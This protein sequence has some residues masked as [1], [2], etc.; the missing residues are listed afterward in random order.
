MGLKFLNFL[1]MSY[2]PQIFQKR[3]PGVDG[4]SIFEFLR[5]YLGLVKVKKG[6]LDQRSIPVILFAKEFPFRRYNKQERFF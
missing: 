1:K 4:F 3:Y 2:F 6:N 5:P